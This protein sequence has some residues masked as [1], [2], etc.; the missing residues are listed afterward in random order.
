[1]GWKGF[2]WGGWVRGGHPISTL[3]EFMLVHI[4]LT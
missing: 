3:A 2:E 1:M 4:C